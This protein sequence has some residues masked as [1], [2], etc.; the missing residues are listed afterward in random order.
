MSKKKKNHH[1][2]VKLLM[3]G[4]ATL[5][6]YLLYGAEDARQNRKKARAWMLKA[7]AEVLEHAEKMGKL[8]REDYEKIISKVESKYKK[9]KSINNKDIAILSKDM[10]KHWDDLEKE[11]ALKKKTTK[12]RK[13]KKTVKKKK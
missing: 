11:F 7:K 3:A 6:T 5:G 2:G 1:A 12:K 8:N 9:L 10:H 4:A 13:S